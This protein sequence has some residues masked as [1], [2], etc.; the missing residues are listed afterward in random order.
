MK[1]VNRELEVWGDG[2]EATNEIR[3]L[4]HLSIPPYLISTQSIPRRNLSKSRNPSA[5]SV[6]LMTHLAC[7]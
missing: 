1:R 6:V 5:A 7:R 3:C 4:R 2:E